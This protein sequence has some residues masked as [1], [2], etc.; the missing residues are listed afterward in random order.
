[1]SDLSDRNI[2]GYNDIVTPIKLSQVYPL[3]PEVE[4]T[5]RKSRT[6]L[7][8]ILDGRDDRKFIIV[9]PCSIHDVGEAR[10]YARRLKGLADKVQDRYV[11]VMRTYFEKPRTGRGWRGLVTDPDL[12]ESADINKGLHLARQLLVYN[13]KSGLPSASELL[14][15]HLPQYFSDTLAWAAVGARTVEPPTHRHMI[16]G[17][18]MPTGVKNART[19]EI[20]IAIEALKIATRPSNFPGCNEYGVLKQVETRGNQYA[21]LILRGGTMNG[22]NYDANSVKAIQ[23]QLRAAELSERIVIDCSHGNSSKDYKRQPMVFRDVMKQIADGNKNIVGLML[24]SNLEEGQQKIPADLTGFDRTKLKRGQSVTDGCIGWK[25]TE[26]LLLE[27][28]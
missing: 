24:E 16:T 21:H 7:E 13:A 1:M 4:D 20:D 27:T 5:I 10:E 12:N 11:V 2:R 28:L 8:N 25:A 3:T 6:Q 15:N 9:G 26:E 17:L 23:D 14:D 22:P 18:S 19:G